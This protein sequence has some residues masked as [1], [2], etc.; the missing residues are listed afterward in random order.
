MGEL[1]RIPDHELH[2]P[3][4]RCWKPETKR[5]FV[6]KGELAWLAIALHKLAGVPEAEMVPLAEH[7][8]DEQGITDPLERAIATVRLCRGCAK[9]TDAPVYALETIPGREIRAVVQPDENAA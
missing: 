7:I 1:G 3:C 5:G 2:E 4:I 8:F 6:V 9:L